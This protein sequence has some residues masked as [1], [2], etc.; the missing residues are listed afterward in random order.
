MAKV[1]VTIQEIYK[2]LCPDCQAAIREL[3]K[4]KLEGS[5]LDRALG[6][7][8]GEEGPDAQRI[9]GAEG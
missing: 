3:V 8:S 2:R 5:A 9:P 4:S 1:N 6:G 7:S